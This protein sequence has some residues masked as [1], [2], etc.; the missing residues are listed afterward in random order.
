MWS[1]PTLSWVLGETE[2][3]RQRRVCRGSWRGALFCLG[4]KRS[5]GKWMVELGAVAWWVSQMPGPVLLKWLEEGLGD[6]GGGKVG[7]QKRRRRL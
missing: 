4:D 1:T 7:A 2:P 6:G 5:V 3:H